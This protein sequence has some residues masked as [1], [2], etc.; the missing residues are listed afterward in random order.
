[1]ANIAE[2]RISLKGLL[3]QDKTV[4][5]PGAYDAV[6]AKLI[7][8]A[9]FPAVYI[10]SYATAASGFGLPDVGLVTMQEMVAHAK[11]IVDAV[12]VPVL[13]DAENGFNNA[14]G[15]WRTVQAFE[16]AGVAGIHIED[17]EFGKHVPVPQ[18]LL[19]IEQMVEKV[20]A[21]LDAREDPNFLIIART[22]AAW[23]LDDLAEAVRRAN[24]FSEAGADMVFLAGCTP[25]QLRTVREDIHG[26][27]VLTDTP[28]FSAQDEED[29]GADVVLYYGFS[30]YAAYQAV[31]VAVTRFK[32]TMNQEDVRDLFADVHEFET[33]AGF[34]D[35]VTKAK[36]YG[37]A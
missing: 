25:E 14:A 3:A 5:V 26:K 28:G 2:R 16:H 33:F 23:A 17:H 36:K 37:L 24:A 8:Q 34:D 31:K 32:E 35:F 11:A 21:A 10:G 7:E 4:I 27:V 6:S 29:A 18:V 22:D 15:V 20:H 30:L 12:S 9:G 1:M 13:A 19:A